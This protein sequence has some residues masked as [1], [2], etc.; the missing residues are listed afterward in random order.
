MRTMSMVV[1]LAITG[2]AGCAGPRPEAWDGPELTQPRTALTVE[3]LQSKETP[4]LLD[5]S[6]LA[7]P[8]WAEETDEALAGTLVLEQTP[9]EVD[10]PHTR[11]LYAGEDRFPAVSLGLVA[12]EGRLLPVRDAR[13]PTDPGSHWDVRAGAGAV[14]REPGDGDWS[15][16]SLPLDLMDRYFNQVRNC[17]ATFLFRDGEVSPVYV[18]CSQETADLADE[19]VGDLRG[20]VGGSFMPG[21]DRDVGEVLEARE[22]EVAGRI[23]V[24]PLAEWDTEGA[25]GELF[26]AFR[27]TRAPTSVGA[28]YVEGTLYVHPARTRHGLHPYPQETRHGV[29][30][31]TKSLAG[32]LALTALSRRYGDGVFDEKVV[33]H[34]PAL[35]D[36]PGWQGVT[37]GN[38]LD[39]ATGTH[40]G[41]ASELLFEPLVLADSADEALARI[42]DLGDAPEAPGEA[43]HYATTHTF[44]LSAALQ[45]LVE[46]RE[47]EGV[48]YWDLVRD[49]VLEP[50]GAAELELLHTRDADP[51][52]RIPT[53]GFGARPTLDE[54]AKIARLFAAEGVHEDRELLDGARVRAALGRT[55]DPGLRVGRTVRYRHAFWRRT[56]RVGGCAVDVAYMQGH[57]GNHVL[58]LP[59]GVI[60]FRFS[61]EHDEDIAPLVRR[62]E[63]IRSSCEGG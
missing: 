9:L 24:R 25:V 11:A 50:I 3:A 54:A 42:A 15:R 19:Q 22:A 13:I 6:F 37:L 7:R 57:G 58:L 16:A 29:Y 38:T 30:S 56:L 46:A 52:A 41:E 53:L 27:T 18:Q 55:A 35:A 1:C 20:T 32:A 10:V 17:V 39:M 61:D 12:S 4:P 21:L 45:H 51:A 44:V 60:V 14:W 28:V 43:F 63:R 47:G 62:V 48:R 34:V 8:A 36:A 59:S 31:V 26:E 2:V 5:L 40:G 49:E 33:D 23:P